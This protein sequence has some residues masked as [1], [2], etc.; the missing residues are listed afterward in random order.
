MMKRLLCLV[1]CLMLFIP[2]AFAETADTLPKRFNRQLTGGNGVRGYMSITT[3]GV[4]EWLNMLLPFTATQIQIRG[5]GEKQGEMSESVMDD[6]D[7]QVRFYVKNDNDQEIGTT[8]LYGDPQGVYFRSELLPDTLLSVPVEQVNLLYQLLRGDYE[9]LFF[10]FDPMEMKVPGAQG[11]ASAY[12]A[13]ANLLGIPAEDWKESWLPVL[14][15][16]FLQLDL[17][18]AGYGD[19]GFVTGETGALTMT[20][21]YEIPA[22]ELK[23]EAKYIIGQMLYDTELQNLLLPYVTLEQRMT[24][25]NPGMVYFYEACIDALP[26]NGDII[27]SR[28]MSALG[29]IVSAKVSLPVP[30]LPEK[31]AAPVGKAAAALFG[32]PYEDLLDGVDRIEFTQNESVKGITLTGAKRSVLIQADVTAP[33][34]YTTAF[35]GTISIVAAEGSQEQ[36]LAAEFDCKVSHKIWADE[37]Y[38]DHDTSTFVLSI[39]PAQDTMSG[40]AAEGMDEFK[41]VSFA[42]TVDYRNNPHQENSAVQVN[43]TL[44]VMV[45]DASVQAE[46]VLRI[47]P[48][49]TMAAL[50]TDGAI[51]VDTIP[52]ERKTELLNEFVSNAIT[53]MANLF[54]ES[55]EIE[56]DASTTAGEPEP[57]SVPPM[58]E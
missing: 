49:L 56:N 37:K 7:W 38:L 17:W 25:L 31:I 15:K 34:E 57:T 20:A 22:D 30:A 36:S 48:Q 10:A 12:E 19:P 54:G 6:D 39:E 29:E 53:T 1:L 33:D 18:L 47:T 40:T 52:D 51:P 44:D 41:P 2:A 11:N 35:D 32:L 27:L 50:T 14:E 13:V 4:A 5:I 55:A 24:Y 58:T 45:P 9:K 46:A 16:Y 21:T 43:Y 26:L 8:W 42:W 3:S 28:E 23:A